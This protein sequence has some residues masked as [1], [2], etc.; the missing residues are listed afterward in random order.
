MTYLSLMQTGY[1]NVVRLDK[2]VQSITG[3]LR[4]AEGWVWDRMSSLKSS[5]HPYSLAILTELRIMTG[6]V[7]ACRQPAEIH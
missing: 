7:I 1:L 6:N 2:F 3:T 4:P 5:R